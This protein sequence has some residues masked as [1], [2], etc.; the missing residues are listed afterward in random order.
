MISLSLS[1][2][3]MMVVIQGLRLVNGIDRIGRDYTPPVDDQ[4]LAT[5]LLE[6]IDDEGDEGHVRD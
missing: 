1:H 6:R 5:S 3:E 2:E 4:V